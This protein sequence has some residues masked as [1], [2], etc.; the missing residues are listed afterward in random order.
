MGRIVNEAK[1]TTRNAR[2]KLAQSKVPHWRAIDRGAHLGYRKGVNGGTWIVRWRKPD[3]SYGTQAIGKA[4]DTLAA[5]GEDCGA[6][7][8]RQLA[9]RHGVDAVVGQRNQG[10]LHALRLGMARLEERQDLS[11]FATIDADGD[12][13]ANELVNLVRAGIYARQERHVGGVHVLGRRI[14]RHRPM[15]WLR[16]ELEELAA[17]GTREKPAGP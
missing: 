11:W 15:G 10:K 3:R 13:F 2:S 16:G 14:S 12:H 1:I 7:V 5:D 6:D 9:A 4:D 17:K 8:V